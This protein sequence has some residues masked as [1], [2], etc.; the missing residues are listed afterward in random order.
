MAYPCVVAGGINANTLHYITNDDV[1]KDGTLVLVDAGGE[2][3]G[4]ASD[5]TRTWPVNGKFTQPQLEL[6]TAVLRANE[7]CI[8][9][10]HLKYDLSLSGIME[11]AEAVLSE[12]LNKLGFSK[13]L[14]KDGLSRFFPHSIGHQLGMDVHDVKSVA[15][16]VKLQ[17]GM[18]VTIEPGIYIP[19]DPDIPEKY[20]GIGIRVEDNVLITESEP[21][22][23]TK[24]AP[25]KTFR[26]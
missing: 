9:R 25:K 19:D 7:Y 10:C 3:E 23:L 13:H 12:E 24:R 26:N 21:D 5:I 20:R 2:Y 8:Q 17:P 22:V 14:Q 1:L 18:I 11:D 15:P 4:Y 6:Y 16:D